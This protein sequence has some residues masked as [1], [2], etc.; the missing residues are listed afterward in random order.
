MAQLL[1]LYGLLAGA[2]DRQPDGDAEPR[3][4]SRPRRVHGPA[5]GIA[6][7][8]PRDEAGLCFLVCLLVF[9]SF[10]FFFARPHRL[11]GVVPPVRMGPATGHRDHP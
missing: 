1:V 9:V 2:D 5:T 3:G 6:W 8:E 10:F 4:R 11:D 7:L